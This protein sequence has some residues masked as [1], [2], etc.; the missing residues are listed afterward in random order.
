MKVRLSIAVLHVLGSAVGVATGE[1]EVDIVAT[2]ASERAATHDCAASGTRHQIAVFV[3]P[4]QGSSISTAVCDVTYDAARVALPGSRNEQS[5]RDRLTGFP[6][7][8]VT[9][10]ND[11]EGKVRVVVTG[12]KSLPRKQALFTADFDLCEGA[13][14]PKAEDYDCVVDSCVATT[15]P[16]EGCTCRVELPTP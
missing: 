6:D 11:M 14:A 10:L 15:T 4:P 7:D 8:T 9:A 16:V 5:V 12:T 2:P 3:A 13:S 1:V